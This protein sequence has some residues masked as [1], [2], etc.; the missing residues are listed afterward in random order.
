M[1]ISVTIMNI[2]III[3]MVALRVLCVNQE[4]ANISNGPMS[5]PSAARKAVT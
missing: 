5:C 4:R 3:T 1:T 2:T